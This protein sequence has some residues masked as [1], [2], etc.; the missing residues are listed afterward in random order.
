MNTAA[1]RAFMARKFLGIPAGVFVVIFAG[2]LLFVAIRMKS[3]D[4]TAAD[5]TDTT[6]TPSGDAGPTDDTQQPDF[7]AVPSDGSTA[8]PV[9]TTVATNDTNDAWQRRAITWLMG[10]GYSVEIATTA[11][12]KYL[13]GGKLTTQEAKAR[14]AAITQFGLP[15]ESIPDSPPPSTGGHP[16]S[17]NAPASK[18]GEPP[19]NH[20]VK[21]NRDN[22]P[23]ELAVLYYG[24]NSADATNK[25]KAA[26]DTKVSPYAVGTKVRI[27]E[28]YVPHFYVA[29]AH[30]KTL[31]DIARKN[32]VD[33]AKVES[34]NPHMEFP[35]KVGTRV[36]VR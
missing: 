21:G 1:I 12:N 28:N 6:D 32:G 30:T 22:T 24:T 34:L 35:V 9:I 27:P 13:N 14:D 10:N 36:R 17:S 2:V 11:I 5:S 4:T 18:Q 20:D 33:P 29:T 26:N 23:A 16:G 19:L 7:S 25:I 31:Y 15:P 8:T 3:S